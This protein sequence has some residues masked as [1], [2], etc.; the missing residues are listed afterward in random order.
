METKP[1]AD[2][3][4]R[5]CCLGSDA[6]A[7]PVPGS[8]RVSELLLQSLEE[9]GFSAGTVLEIGSGDGWLSRQL[10]GLGAES[11]TG[12]DLSPKSVEHAAARAAEAG[13]SERLSYRVADAAHARLGRYDVVL[14]DKVFCCYPSLHRLL[15]NTLPAAGSF[16]LLALPESR[17]LIGL[18]SRL[19]VAVENGLRRVQRDPFRAYV[20]DVRAMERR[21]ASAGF[22]RRVARRHSGWLVLAFR[23][24]RASGSIACCAA[25]PERH[26][27]QSPS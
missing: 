2:Y 24:A 19:V 6:G 15:D 11:V 18:A 10:L 25:S 9:A 3:F 21:I 26:V 5:E 23:R 8:D 17:G 22:R 16:Y 20:H 7:S 27:A 13:L 14:S 1:I 4:D 12:L